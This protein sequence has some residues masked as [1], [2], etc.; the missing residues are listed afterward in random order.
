MW[1]RTCQVDTHTHGRSSKCK[2]S[3]PR[4]HLRDTEKGQGKDPAQQGWGDQRAPRG[5]EVFAPEQMLI[6]LFC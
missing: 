3:S 4:D 1:H 5:R 6:Q 2:V